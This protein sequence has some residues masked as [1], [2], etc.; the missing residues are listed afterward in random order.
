[1]TI[2][3]KQWQLYYLGYYS[4]K[5]DGIWG[6]QSNAAAVRFQKDSDLDADGVFGVLTIA[7]SIEII[8]AIQ[9]E[10]TD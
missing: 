3:Q 5:L 8:K 1:M 4:G 2:Q 9:K 7:K 6:A 10:I